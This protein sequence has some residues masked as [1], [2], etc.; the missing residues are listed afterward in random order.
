MTGT[1]IGQAPELN[2]EVQHEPNQSGRANSSAC[3][4]GCSPADP[5]RSQCATLRSSSPLVLGTEG[6]LHF[7][8]TKLVLITFIAT[9][10]TA[11]AREFTNL[12]FEQASVRYVYVDQYNFRLDPALAFPGWTLG[13]P[14]VLYNTQTIGSPALTLFGPDSPNPRPL[15]G[16]YSAYL[17]YGALP[18]YT[19]PPSLSQVGVVPSD[20]RLITF[21]FDG[22]SIFHVTLGGVEIP[23]F[24]IEGGRRAG[25]VSA[26]AGQEAKLEFYTENHYVVT[27][28]YI[29]DITFSTVP[30]PTTL[31]SAALGIV[32][33]FSGRG[34]RRVGPQRSKRGTR[35]S[36]KLATN[37]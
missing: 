4:A 7:M 8:T 2:I 33:L 27:A 13:S 20:A 16:N 6:R 19:G 9:L 15:E 37:A 21:L 3:H 14:H 30:E 36:T 25:D 24:P 26:F 1:L 34:E 28:L 10:Q 17:Q 29:D 32:L 11:I 22:G 5:P 12:D 23:T 18:P 31:A 35:G